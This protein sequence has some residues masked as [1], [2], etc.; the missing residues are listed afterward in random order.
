MYKKLDDYVKTP[1]DYICRLYFQY[2]ENY[3]S[4]IFDETL[5]DF[6]NE[7]TRMNSL[8]VPPPY[9]TE[10]SLYLYS[11]V[12]IDALFDDVKQFECQSEYISHMHKIDKY[13]KEY[14]IPDR[15]IRAHTDT[16]EE[17]SEPPQD[18]L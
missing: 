1:D 17:L 11:L 18:A 4:F 3:E 16:Q 2:D 13:K 12:G 14:C 9:L 6:L 10:D 15:N 7:L 5:P 8:Y